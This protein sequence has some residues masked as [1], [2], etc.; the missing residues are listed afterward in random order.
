M[1]PDACRE[2]RGSLA[3]AALGRLEPGEAIALRAHL[4][5]CR[6]CRA[7]L[8]EL[9]G[10]AHVLPAADLGNLDTDL[11]EPVGTLGDMVLESVAR[12]RG[13]RRD[14]R[15]RQ[16][17]TA[18]LA[19]AAVI[20]IVVGAV[21]VTIVRSSD[22]DDT[23]QVRVEFTAPN[24]EGNAS[25]ML[26]AR[27]EGTEVAFTASGLDEGEWYWLWT[28]GA[29]DERVSAGTFQGASGTSKL[30]LVSA[31]PL[32]ETTRVWVTSGDDRVVFDAWLRES[33]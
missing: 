30:H 25:A 15:M 29:D 24:G 3:S 21:A 4:D 9:E 13:A 17:R 16:V 12:E 10:V 27:D 6:E 8:T 20:A 31:L 7:E 2:W 28:T 19:A 18:I 14:R 1:T 23:R 22:G 33:T 32:D 11:V 5:G 26:T